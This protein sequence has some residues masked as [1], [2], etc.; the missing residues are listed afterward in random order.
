M[1]FRSFMLHVDNAHYKYMS[2][3]I[4]L[5]P[6]KLEVPINVFKECRNY[7]M[8]LVVKLRGY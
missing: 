8:I 6:I 2:A 1:I 4:I 3:S 5:I 7:K